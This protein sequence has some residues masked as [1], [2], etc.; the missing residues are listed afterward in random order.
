MK[1]ECIR[2]TGPDLPELGIE[3]DMDFNEVIQKINDAI[4][5][6]ITTTTTTSTSTSTTTSS[7]TTTTTTTFSIPVSISYI[8]TSNVSSYQIQFIQNNVVKGS[9]IKNNP[10]GSDFSNVNLVPGIY[11]VKAIINLT[12]NLRLLELDSAAITPSI[13]DAFTSSINKTYTNRL[14]TNPSQLVLTDFGTTTTTTTSSTTTTTTTVPATTTT[15]STTSTSTSST[16]TTTTTALTTTTTSTSTTS[17]STSSTTTTTSTNSSGGRVFTITGTGNDQISV[18]GTQYSCGDTIILKGTFN[19]VEFLNLNGCQGNPITITNPVGQFTVIGNQN[20]NGG[21]WSTALAFRN[22]HYINLKGTAKENFVISGSTQT[23]RTAYFDLS[24]IELSDN[25]EV[26]NITI[27]NG[28]T[29]L[30]A[31]TEPVPGNSQTYDPIGGPY[32]YLNNFKFYDIEIKDTYNE[33]TY[34]GHTGPYW[35]L[36]TNQQF[37]GNP[38]QFVPGHTYVEPKR[39]Y[40]VEIY[41]LFVHDI[42]ADGIQTAA[43]ESMIIHHNEVYNWATRQDS[44]HNGGIQV[45]GKSRNVEV[46]CNYVH[47]GWGELG[48]NYADGSNG[49]FLRIHNNLFVNNYVNNGSNDGISFKLTNNLAAEFYD[50]TVVQTG[51]NNLRFYTGTSHQL[52]RNILIKPR[53][54]GGTISNR[55]YIYD[56]P[57]TSWIEGTGANSNGKY[58]DVITANVDPNNW[59]A[60]NPGSPAIGKGYIRGVCDG[61]GTTT[62]STTSTSTTSTST[63]STSTT[64]STTTTTTTV[65]TTTT[66]STSTTSTTSTSTSSTSSTTTTS[67]TSAGG[68]QFLKVSGWKTGSP[69]Q[70]GWLYLPPNYNPTGAAYPFVIFLHG[71]GQVGSGSTSVDSLLTMG[72]PKFLNAGDRPSGIIIFCPQTNVNTW[73]PSDIELAR[74]YVLNNCNADVDRFYLTGLSLGG[75]GTSKYVGTYPDRVA[76]YLCATGD[77]QWQSHAAGTGYLGP[78]GSVNGVRMADVP[79]WFHS[80]MADTQTYPGGGYSAMTAMNAISPK[81]IYP[82]LVNIYWGLTHS[83]SLWDNE[84]YNRKNRTDTTGLADFDYIDWFKQFKRND[85]EFNATSLVTNSENSHDWNDYRIASRVVN[86]MSAGP[87]KTSLLNRL[88]AVKSTIEASWKIIELNFG[89]T[90]VSGNFNNLTTISAGQSVNNMVDVNGGAT[91]IDFTITTNVWSGDV[92]LGGLNHE[93]QGMPLNFWAR[94]YRINKPSSPTET[95]TFSGLSNTKTYKI[96]LY[97]S[98]VTQATNEHRGIAATVGSTT[99][100]LDNEI[101]NTNRYLE[102]TN[103]VPSGGN[104]VMSVAPLISGQYGDV[105]GLVIFESVSS[106]TTTTTSTTSTSTTSTSTT[107]STTTSSTTTTTTTLPGTTTTTTSTSSTSTTST[108]TSSTTSTTTSSTTTTTTT[109][110]PNIAQFNF[111]LTSQTVSGWTSAFGDPSTGV[112]TATAP[113][114]IGISSIATTRWGAFGA[115]ANDTN[116]ADGSNAEFPSEVINSYWFSYGVDPATGLNNIEING[117]T[118][119][120]AYDL[121][122]IGSRQSPVS[123]GTTRLMLWR[124]TDANGTQD[125]TNYD[126][127]ANLTNIAVFSNKVADGS[128]KMTVGIF[129][130]AA[131]NGTNG[132]EYAY[133]NGMRVMPH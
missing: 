45:G 6:G 2:Y 122:L 103:L 26:S 39:L 38:S 72:P 44:S 105:A 133:L 31:K 121:H 56:E 126:C 115:S 25:F 112:R 104:I 60:P 109:V 80:G 123:P 62:T 1:G 130:D 10:V 131:G 24:I 129:R 108:S 8:D 16:T 52:N 86:L 101:Q 35:D 76:A 18:D 23:G 4:S 132:N 29:G 11:D 58:P 78:D 117:L 68:G 98:F 32:T 30:Y 64:S 116:G 110:N 7:S 27:Q 113:N 91:T 94:A 41:N 106:N 40:N 83:A 65:A 34:I 102:F 50:N 85:I 119:G 69:N 36:T 96:R 84:V 57:G 111:S 87:S 63:S 71:Q 22:C 53:S 42:G 79:G 77:T 19:A 51:G 9:Y 127:L 81:P 54:A 125:I 21:S 107:T 61:T 14:I 55:A 82:Y 5:H 3:K 46:Y 74:N 67:T 75:S 114:G 17:T 120:A 49:S 90:T 33:G 20:W 88:S 73:E 47:D 99:I 37:N 43:A 66:T 93:Y 124:C 89:T 97:P 100:N 12:N 28:G 13:E 128:G 70:Y 118:P 48:Q 15:T 59:Y 95:W 92:A